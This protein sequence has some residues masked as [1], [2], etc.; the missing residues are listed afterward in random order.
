M[1]ILGFHTAVVFGL[2]KDFLFK[3][4][5]GQ[6]VKFCDKSVIKRDFLKIIKLYR[7]RF[8]FSFQSWITEFRGFLGRLR[9]YQWIL[10]QAFQ[11]V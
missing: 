8:K 10:F 5:L 1:L 7:R 6:S 11:G 9:K 2:G 4:I 3:S